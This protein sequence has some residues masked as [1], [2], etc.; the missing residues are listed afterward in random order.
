MSRARL[1]LVL[2]NLA[3]FAAWLGAFRKATWSDGD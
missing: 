3:M 1:Y 2:L